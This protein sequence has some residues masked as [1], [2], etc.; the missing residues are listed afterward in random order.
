MENLRQKYGQWA[1]VLGAIDG[2]GKEF[3]VCFAKARVDCILVGRRAEKLQELAGMLEKTYGI[4]TNVI[5]ADLAKDDAAENLIR[6]VKDLDVGILNY[7][8][9]FH[10]MGRY[11]KH[12]Y[13][14]HKKVLNVNVNTYSKLVYYFSMVFYEKNRGA[15]VTMSSLTAFTGNQVVHADSDQ[16]PRLRVPGTG[17]D[18]IV[19]TAGSTKTPDW[20][21]NQLNG[22]G[23]RQLPGDDA[24]GGC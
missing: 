17:V 24:A 13:E 22:G 23:L 3:A 10:I 16:V 19:I 4:K 15:V 9:T 18:I 8:A 6:Q 1:F 21:K 7:V 11:F 2:I 20:L 12:P 14:D 5:P